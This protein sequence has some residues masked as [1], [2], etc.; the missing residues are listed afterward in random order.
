M[1]EI[2]AENIHSDDLRIVARRDADC[3][4]AAISYGAS[5]ED[6]WAGYVYTDRPVYRPGHTVHFKGILR[7]R[8]LTG[9][10]VPAAK[11]VSVEIQDP[12][13]KPIYRKSLTTSANGTVHDEFTLAPGAALGNYFIA[14]HAGAE[15]E[16]SGNFEVE[17]YKKPEYEVRVIPGKLRILEGDTAQVT[18]DARYYFGE[19]VSGAKVKYDVYRSRYWFPLW[20]DADEES[21]E[22]AE[23]NADDDS[24]G[25]QILDEEGKLDQ[26]GKLT[27]AFPT[28]QSSHKYDYRYRVEAHV[29]DEALREITGRGSVIAT[30][31]SF[32]VNVTP[33]RYVYQP[34]STGSFTVEA[35]DYEN[36]PV[37][38]R[39]HVELI[40]WN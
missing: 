37:A 4:V 25:D 36:N 33:D 31:G 26:D 17:E 5:A 38:T 35:R 15:T 11:P 29:T 7:V 16:M 19:P 20:Y 28:A 40:Q 3:A 27:I 23:A 18:I 24:G 1:A 32:V 10:D 22:P 9:Y 39:L 6:R 12:E 21:D 34:G 13:Q 14:I 8:S 2:K 30:Y